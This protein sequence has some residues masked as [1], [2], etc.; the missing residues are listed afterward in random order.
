M[1][2]DDGHGGE[3]V[4]EGT[5]GVQGSEAEGKGV[6]GYCLATE[7]MAGEQAA[8]GFPTGLTAGGPTAAQ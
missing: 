2:S 4:M 7:G 8:A 1:V 5:M 3:L 6:A